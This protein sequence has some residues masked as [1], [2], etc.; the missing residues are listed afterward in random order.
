MVS[1]K[2]RRNL[3]L[4]SQFVG[5]WL[6]RHDDV[7]HFGIG[8][9]IK[10]IQQHFWFLK[11]QKYVHNYIASCIECCYNRAKAG[12]AEGQMYISELEPIHFFQIH[13]DH[14]GPFVRSR[15]LVNQ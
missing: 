8:K 12:K 4:L 1:K 14:L 6:S 7:G 3:L 10:R 11:M 15:K 13:L 9:T 5:G 2:A